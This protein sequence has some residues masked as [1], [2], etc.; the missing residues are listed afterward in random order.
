MTNIVH[1]DTG[2]AAEGGWPVD[3]GRWADMHEEEQQQENAP[4]ATEC[5]ASQGSDKGGDGGDRRSDH[6]GHAWVE[7]PAQGSWQDAPSAGGSA[8]WSWTKGS[9]QEAPEAGGWARAT[10]AT[11]PPVNPWGSS[12]GRPIS[13]R[14]RFCNRRWSPDGCK[15]D[16]CLGCCPKEDGS[17]TC[18]R[19][20][21]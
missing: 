16:A 21:F 18:L 20:S 15:F 4:P 14:C 11:P 13:L 6:W 1:G 9:W 19:H 8:S 17:T 12:G 3:R 7:E 5:I 2:S 10:F